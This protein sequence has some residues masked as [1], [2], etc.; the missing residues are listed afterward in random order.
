MKKKILK[1]LLFFLIGFIAFFAFR[2]IYGY[3]KYD[4]NTEYIAVDQQNSGNYYFPESNDG[5]T[6]TNI[7]S[8]KYEGKKESKPNDNYIPASTEQK[9]EKIGSMAAKT[10]EFEKTEKKFR[11]LI[12]KYDALIQ[13]E[14]KYGL[15]GHRSLGM[16]VGVPPN[17]FDAMIE[18][19]KALG[20]LESIQ[21]DKVDKTNE[22]KEL[23]AQRTSLEKTLAS[24]TALKSK[25][26]KIDEYVNLEQ[27]I[28]DYEKQL[29]ELGVQL[30]DYD[31]ENEFCTVKYNLTEKAVTIKESI[32]FL[33][34]VMVALQWTIKFYF[35]FVLIVAFASL[36]IFLIL[37]AAQMFKWIQKPS[38]K[39]HE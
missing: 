2:L 20:K 31:A 12:K 33:Y 10:D 9:Y 30:G 14:Q 11:D 8:S 6:K 25:G 3:V 29:Q 15:P 19:V 7:A 26:G 28:L 37:K 4:S 27:Q 34:R 21:I 23:N 32:P 1:G 5:N 13:Y 22:Y 16:T 36:A 39:K 17:N 24:L 35:V 18:E 38:D